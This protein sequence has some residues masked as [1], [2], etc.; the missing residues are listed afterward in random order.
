MIA[1]TA[2]APGW[3]AATQVDYQKVAIAAGLLVLLMVLGYLGIMLLRR[4]L[5][6]GTTPC[7]AKASLPPK[8]TN[9]HDSR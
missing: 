8:S 4:R 3:I 5:Y 6:E 7:I 2:N 9:G 1:A